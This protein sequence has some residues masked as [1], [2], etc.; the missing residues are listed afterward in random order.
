MCG[1]ADATDAVRDTLTTKW[2]IF[3]LTPVSYIHMYAPECMHLNNRMHV[4]TCEE[5]HANLTIYEVQYE[6]NFHFFAF[7][8]ERFGDLEFV[9]SMPLMYKWCI[10]VYICTYM[11][12]KKY[13]QIPLNEMM[14]QWRNLLFRFVFWVWVLW[15]S[16]LPF[17]FPDCMF[18]RSFSCLLGSCCC[19]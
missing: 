15:I 13:I 2:Q 3:Y 19:S 1:G 7:S 8:W 4:C 18:V 16:I 11:Y 14:I 17:C 9:K 6:E 5:I 10:H 12:S